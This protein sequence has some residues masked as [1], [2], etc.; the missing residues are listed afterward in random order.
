MHKYFLSFIC[1]TS[2]LLSQSVIKTVTLPTGTYWNS[3]YGL[4]YANGLY[5]ISSGS[6][7]L[8]KG[9]FYGVDTNGVVVDSIRVTN[10]PSISYSQGLAFDGTDFWYVERKTAGSALY[11]ISTQGLVLDSI[12]LS[13][14]GGSNSWYL[15]GA[16]CEPGYI[17]I[18]VYYPDDLS[19]MFKINTTTKTIVDTIAALQLQ[20][21]GVAV[22]GDTLY[23][24]NDGFQGTDRM[25]AVNKTT[26]DTFYTFS[27]PEQPGLRQN[28]RG[29]AWDGNYLWLLAEPIGASTGRALFKYDLG[30]QGNP[31]IS[32]ITKNIDYGNVQIDSTRFAVG[33]V[34]NYG[35]APLRIDSMKFSG[36]AFTLSSPQ[37]PYTIDP[38]IT[39]SFTYSFKPT[40]YGAYHDS[41]ILYHNDGTAPISKIIFKGFGVHTAPY[42]S[43]SESALNYGN[44]RIKST[45]SKKLAIS[46]YGSAVLRIDSL[47]IKN[48]LF[49]LQETIVPILIDSQKTK[50]VRL[51]FQPLSYISYT[52]T[53]IAY[54]NAS[55]GAVQKIIL[56]AVGSPFDSTLGN[57]VWEDVVPPN[58]DVTYQDYSA[59]V[60][61]NIE[62]INGDGVEDVIV[63]T[64]N[65]LTIAYNG[66]SSGS[67]DILWTFSSAPNNSNTGAVTR[68]QALQLI[69]D[70]NN[71]GI[72][73]VVIGTGGGNEFVYALSGKTGAKLW[74]YGDSINYSQGDINGLDTRRD[75]T[76]DNFPDVIVSASGNESTGEGRF[77][78]ILLNGKTGQEVWRIS[79][80][81]Q[82]KLK[83]AIVST[84]DG[85][86]VGSKS[87]G[88]STGEVIGFDRNGT[89]SWAFPTSRAV[90]GLDEIENIG[91]LPT[92]DL[93][94]GDVGGNVY[95]ISG[96]AGVQIWTKVIGNYFIEDLFVIPDVNNSGTDDILISPLTSSI[97]VLE[98]SNGNTIFSGFTGGNVL[99][100]SLLGDMNADSVAEIG[101]GSLNNMMH[102]FN[103]K[104]GAEIYSLRFPTTSGEAVETVWKL[105]DIDG[106]GSNEFI[107]GSRNGLVIA[108]SGG[109]DVISSAGNEEIF[110]SDFHLFQ[111]YPNPFNPTT[112]IRFAIPA[113]MKAELKIYDMLGSEVATLFNKEL[114]GGYH[115]IEWNG[116]N[117]FGSPVSSGIYIYK[118]SAGDFVQSKKMILVR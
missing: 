3:G 87:S 41:V 56:S 112:Q 7:T 94:A 11:K 27:V 113:P 107:A 85:G 38:G 29:L 79:H 72:K 73:D 2:L 101:T 25:Y 19:G 92:S 86:A 116:N 53:L 17:W 84:D 54:T 33:Y 61:K 96:D 102:V 105:G 32:L 40:T 23:Y 4:V 37:L 10:Y 63:C 111:N 55:N 6:S 80:A 68:Q 45:S 34:Q 90:W 95:A 108:F 9:V 12:I 115:S 67:G 44:K 106:N 22:N 30:G 98:G 104:T 15:G 46:N 70:I 31:G 114:T 69:K 97:F 77:A 78:V 60:I 118:L 18:S 81:V 8:G 51:W 14:A 50:V 39:A 75:W 28:P 62:D 13:N 65:Y 42:I 52:D 1:L 59:K 109:T 82:K 64:E 88:G 43:L 35:T 21:T 89:T 48:N 110:V 71:D 76:N 100:T 99:G 26:K 103:G 91:G 66:N 57:F 117:N 47:V 36:S 5:W 16:A 93:I 58:P 24:V 20:P 83:D 49:T 74:E